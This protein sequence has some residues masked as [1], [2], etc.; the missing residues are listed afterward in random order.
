MLAADMSQ[1]PMRQSVGNIFSSVSA[2]PLAPQLRNLATEALVEETCA[3]ENRIRAAP[4]REKQ[5]WEDKG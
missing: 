5:Y 2:G 4:G 1:G 3:R